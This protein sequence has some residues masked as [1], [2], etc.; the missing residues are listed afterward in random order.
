MSKIIASTYEIIKEIGSGGGGVVY[1]GRHLR[2][3]KLIVLKADK[4]D[5]TAKPDLLR[6]EVD[7]LKNLSHTYI[8][9]VYDFVQEDGVVYTVMDYIEGES[10]DKPLE[11]GE[12]FEQADIVKWARQLLEALSYLHS[13]PPHGILHSDIKPANI[14]ITPQGDIRLI[15]FN[16]AL[17]LGEEG[18]VR[19]G[20]SRG[21]ASPEHYGVDF[22]D[23]K[24]TGGSGETSATANAHGDDGTELIDETG[25]TLPVQSRRRDRPRNSGVS[26]SSNI[27]FKS[28]LSDTSSHRVVLLDKRSDIYGVGATLY[29]VITGV[30]PHYKADEV[31]PITQ[32]ENVNPCIAAIIRKAM[33][34][35]P[36]LRYQTADE[37]LYDFERLHENDP[38][39]KRHRRHM[40]EAAALVLAGFLAGASLIYIGQK[41]NNRVLELEKFATQSSEA[42]RAGDQDAALSFALRALPTEGGLYNPPEP[43]SQARLAL[44]NALGV[45]RL[46][47]AYQPWTQF[48]LPGEPIK[49]RIS[50][51]GQFAAALTRDGDAWKVRIFDLEQKEQIGEAEAEPASFSEILFREN[52]TLLFAGINGLSCFDPARREV[53]WSTGQPAT[54]ISA[55]ENIIATVYRDADRAYFFDADTGSPVREP[56]SFDGKRMKVPSGVSNGEFEG[57][58]S[59]F[60]LNKSGNRLAVSFDD[61]SAS[62]FDLNDSAGTLS[63]PASD[64]THFDGAFN[65]DSLFALSR[66]Q[67]GTANTRCEILY[68]DSDGAYP[69]FEIVPTQSELENGQSYFYNIISLG[70]AF[71][72]SD[73]KYL[74][75]VDESYILAVLDTPEDESLPALPVIADFMGG[76]MKIAGF[77]PGQEREIIWSGGA[78]YYIFNQNGQR[79]ETGLLND[80]GDFINRAAIEGRF[81]ALGN[82]QDSA[83]WVKKLEDHEK[84]KI[85]TYDSSY[86]HQE[87][88]MR[89]D[90]VAVLF[91]VDGFRI[92]N[93]DQ[94]IDVQWDDVTY[95]PQYRRP[96]DTDFLQ[97]P[98]T[99]ELLEMRYRNGRIVGYSVWTGERLYEEWGETPDP[100]H[101]V[102]KFQTADYL[103]V[104]NN[105]GA[106]EIYDA[107]GENLL[108]IMEGTNHLAYARQIGDYLILHYNAIEEDQQKFYGLLLDRNLETVAELPQLCDYLPDGT[109]IF[110]DMFGNL[111][112][113]RIYSIDELISTARERGGN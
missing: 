111:R 2:L 9:Q 29:H 93:P 107:S 58:F 3:D 16:I 81:I 1:L 79:I 63:V 43:L 68:V 73:L 59:M 86:F 47:A 53:V 82:D 110:D 14:M 84:A 65:G 113:S 71:Y 89:G 61:G 11:R 70:K 76:E 64:Y 87:A 35:N 101:P 51:D 39:S 27:S 104:S 106:P 4:R 30:R 10:L 108:K 8:P 97:R 85:F 60:A 95:D 41:Q 49:L 26:A 42:F 40:A 99:E 25:A 80:N 17:I 90:G 44:T 52:G 34:P 20:R 19:V 75:R 103:V 18:A 74:Y 112:Q 66:A 45:Y 21:Y 5:L 37:M 24:S 50:Q 48:A 38:R 28:S 31:V 7:A 109:L 36:D 69:L 55:G 33:N 98:V 13:R 57:K 15:D 94:N 105:R 102:N 96:G 88:R 92:C 91:G 6:G 46:Q 72:I 77:A 100:E 23:S 78:E 62:I 83:L 56:L 22:R 12:K 32:M 67:S 54:G